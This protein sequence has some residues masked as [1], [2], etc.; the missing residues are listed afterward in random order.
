MSR[1][2]FNIEDGQ[3]LL[4]PEGMDL[5]SL[6]DAKDEAMHSA[7]DLLRG[8]Q[9][10]HLWNGLPWRMWVTDEPEGRGSTLFTLSFS[11]ASS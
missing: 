10:D 7:F 8:S 5:A 9:K 1:Y 6:Q 11:A 2:F 4:D 3:C